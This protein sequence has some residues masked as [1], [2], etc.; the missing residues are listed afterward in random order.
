ME[1]QEPIPVLRL[2]VL[3]PMES[4]QSYSGS[5]PRQ[6]QGCRNWISCMLHLSGAITER[7]T[8]ETM[9]ASLVSPVIK[10]SIE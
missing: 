7:L 5:R 9:R 8:L 3:L 4:S 1:M 10:S 6:Y 2:V